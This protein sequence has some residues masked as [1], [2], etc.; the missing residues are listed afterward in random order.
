MRRMMWARE[1]EK[2]RVCVY[3]CEVEKEAFRS[4]HEWEKKNVE[5]E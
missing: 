3:L 1:R 5:G 4:L 2:E